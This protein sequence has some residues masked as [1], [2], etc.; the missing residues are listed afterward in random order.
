MKIFIKTIIF[1][2]SLLFLFV[3]I[4]NAASQALTGWAWSDNIGWIQ[5]NPAFGG[6]FINDATGAFS[7]Y[8]W[9]DNIGWIDFNGVNL[10]LTTGAVTGWA[11][12]VAADGNG[13]DG[14]ISMSGTSPNYEVSMNLSTGNFSGWAW[15]SDVVGWVSFN[16]SVSP[17]VGSPSCSGCVSAPPVP[18][19]NDGID[20]DSNGCANFPN[21]SGCSSAS[22]NN[23]SGG[24]CPLP[25]DFTLSNSNVILATII[26]SRSTVSGETTI[27]V[28]D[29][30][31]FSDDVS[32]S[33]QSISPAMP[34]VSYNFGDSTLSSSEYSTGS[35]FRV[36]VPGSA[37]KGLYIITVRGE[38]GGLVRTVEIRLNV[39]EL[40]PG[41]EEF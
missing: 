25:P 16:G 35:T 34:G 6:V 20:N 29:P 14:R 13:W 2:L 27:T 36:N 31:N 18:Q 5:F 15:G 7:G 22:D 38:D 11:D 3:G 39:E 21:D 40:D 26:E 4:A 33:A 28:T 8:A 30:I 1:S 24:S 23:E 12:A 32:L 17:S 37:S 41:W 19:C 9:S 10:N